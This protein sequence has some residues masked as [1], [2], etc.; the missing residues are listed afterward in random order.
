MLTPEELAML[1]ALL[2]RAISPSGSLHVAATMDIQPGDVV[3]IRPGI[4]RAWESSLILVTRVEGLR[5]RGQILRPHR[6]GCSE[7]W[8]SFRPGE[9]VRIGHAPFPQPA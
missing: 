6:S 4:D 7:A 9:V 8:Y 3:E 1:Q 5:C 2:A